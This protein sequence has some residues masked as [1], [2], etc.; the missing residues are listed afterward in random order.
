MARA[1]PVREEKNPTSATAH[2]KGTL[3]LM[4]AFGGEI[5]SEWTARKRDRAARTLCPAVELP[6]RKPKA[7]LNG[8]PVP[9][10]FKNSKSGPAPARVGTGVSPVQV[11][12]SSTA[13]QIPPF[14]TA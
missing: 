4:F 14:A 3:C 9:S 8:P 11:E 7:G 2:P 5:E 10:N 6:P 13:K 12:R 1:F